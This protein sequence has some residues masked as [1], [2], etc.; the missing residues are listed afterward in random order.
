MFTFDR[1]TCIR[2]RVS[3]IH[4]VQGFSVPTGSCSS[5][6]MLRF[7]LAS[8]GS[9]RSR[10]S[11]MRAA[12]AVVLMGSVH[13]IKLFRDFRRDITP[14][15]PLSGC[16]WSVVCRV[17]PV[18]LAIALLVSDGAIPASTDRLLVFVGLMMVI[19]NKVLLGQ[20]LGQICFK[21]RTS[22]R[23]TV[24]PTTS[25]VG[26]ILIIGHRFQETSLCDK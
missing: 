22:E 2:N 19:E 16:L 7:T 6:L 23:Q 25:L 3:A 4:N 8:I 10:H 9:S 26:L 15:C 14:K 18:R 11:Y 1:S 13:F 5:G 20:Y 24:G 12:F 17:R 21:S